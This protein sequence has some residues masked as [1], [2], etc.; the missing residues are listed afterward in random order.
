MF[1]IFAEN[2]EELVEG[3]RGPPGAPGVGKPG[4]QGPP[5]RVGSQGTLYLIVSRVRLPRTPVENI[6]KNRSCL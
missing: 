4:S 2:F 6:S 3:L 1:N 5:G